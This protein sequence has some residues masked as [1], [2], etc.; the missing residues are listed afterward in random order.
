[1]QRDEYFPPYMSLLSLQM[2]VGAICQT[3]SSH[4]LINMNS[5]T[6]SLIDL[7]IVCSTAPYIIPGLSLDFSQV[8]A[9]TSEGH[10]LHGHGEEQCRCRSV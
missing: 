1:M 4:E 2:K 7:F 6:G 3:C 10:R 5:E 9:K 8:E